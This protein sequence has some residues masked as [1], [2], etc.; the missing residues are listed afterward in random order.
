MVR[1][2]ATHPGGRTL[3]DGHDIIEVRAHPLTQR[4]ERPTATSWGRYEEVSI[5][6]VEVRTR[7]GFVGVGEALARFA[8]AAYASLIE[9]ALRPRL[10][11]RDATTIGDL[12][13]GMRRALSGRAGGVLVEA[14]AAVDIAL[15]DILGKIAG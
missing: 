6:L 2:S 3:S 11:G 15:W 14:I 10:M 13:Q 9:T 5:V 4:L 8:P 1:R 7:S 12:W